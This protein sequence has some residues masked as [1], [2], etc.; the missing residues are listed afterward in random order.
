[1]SDRSEIS[2]CPRPGTAGI[3]YLIALLASLF[4]EVYVR[5]G[6]IV[7]GNAADTAATLQVFEALYRQGLAADLVR[8][9]AS[10]VVTL[11]LHDFFKPVD[12]SLS[13]LATFFS[14]IGLAVLAVN[15]LLHL[16]PVLFLNSASSASGLEVGH[17]QDLALM[18]LRLHAQGSSLSGVFFGFYCFLIG[19]LVFRSLFL[20]R[21]VGV[22]MAA[23]GLSYL[24]HGFASILAPDL[25]SGFPGLPLLGGAAELLFSL[26]LMR[27]GARSMAGIFE[28]IRAALWGE[29]WT[30]SSSGL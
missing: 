9:V 2:A 7:P 10:V 6:L 4:A 3:F 21:G 11:L 23:G 5:G 12:R 22:L 14:L 8:I 18:C 27:K 15:S 29:P 19:C 20:P 16:A 13:L 1:M 25:A 26:W 30:A 24:A 28:W 17:W